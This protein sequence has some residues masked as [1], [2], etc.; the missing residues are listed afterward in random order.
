MGFFYGSILNIT[1]IYK[2]LW[3]FKKQKE[4]SYELKASTNLKLKKSN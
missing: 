4:I 1:G 2:T 3:L